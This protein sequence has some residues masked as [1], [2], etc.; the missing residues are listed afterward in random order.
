RWDSVAGP[1]IPECVG[2]DAFDPEVRCSTGRIG[3]QLSSARA[4]YRGL[5][6]RFEK[7]FSRGFQFLASYALSKNDGFN[8]VVNN[9]D[10]FESYGPLASDRRHLFTCSGLLELP[11]GLRLSFISSIMSRPPYT[12]QLFGLDLNGDGTENDGLPDAGWNSLNRTVGEEELPRVVQAFNQKYAGSRTPRDQF[13]PEIRL[14]P[15]YEF[16]DTMFSQDFRLSWRHRFR[17]RWELNIFGEVFN[18]FNV[19]NLSGYSFDLLDPETFGQP[20]LRVNQVFG[21]GGP[22]AF[23]LGARLSF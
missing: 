19:A 23:Q 1:V 11:A 4:K 6:A 5:L 21:S 2:V 7:R 12:A 13:I 18:L 17:E 16:G 15:D 9:D 3:V 14:P 20:L 10:W 22:R 8:G